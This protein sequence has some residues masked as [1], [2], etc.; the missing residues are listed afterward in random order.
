ML[1]FKLMHVFSHHYAQ[2]SFESIKAK[3]CILTEEEEEV[4][5]SFLTP[6]KSILYS[7]IRSLGM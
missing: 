6:I 7:V 5:I 2:R 4:L 1:L 3:Y